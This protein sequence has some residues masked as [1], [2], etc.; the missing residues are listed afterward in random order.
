MALTEITIDLEEIQGAIQGAHGLLSLLYRQ[1]KSRDKMCQWVE[2]A[3]II[4]YFISPL[5]F[6]GDSQ[7]LSALKT[8]VIPSS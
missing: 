2:L 3:V 5:E 1:I 8:V 6:A 7:S 4:A